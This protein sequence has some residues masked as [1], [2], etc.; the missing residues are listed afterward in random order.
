[1]RSRGNQPEN[2]FSRGPGSGE[3]DRRLTKGDLIMN[4]DARVANEADHRR[5][6][7]DKL[8]Q[9]IQLLEELLDSINR[10]NS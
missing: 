9:I 3:R 1:M 8:A 5:R 6:V 2:A 7:E 4:D 10:Q